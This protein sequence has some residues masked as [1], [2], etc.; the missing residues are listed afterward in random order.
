MLREMSPQSS[1]RLLTD[2]TTVAEKTIRQLR[3]FASQALGVTFIAVSH[4]SEVVPEKW[5]TAIGEV[6]NIFVI[7][8]HESEL[9]AR[10]GLGVS[11]FYHILN[12]SSLSLC[13]LPEEGIWNRSTES[14][15]RW[16]T[17][18]NF[19]TDVDGIVRWIQVASSAG[20]IRILRKRSGLLVCS[21]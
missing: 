6:E 19:A 7:V 10:W 1:C 21:F 14:G 8:D 17:A 18:G 5:L 11:S 12:P 3:Q 2:T 15:T 9:Y 13:G 4:T 16:Q 20:D